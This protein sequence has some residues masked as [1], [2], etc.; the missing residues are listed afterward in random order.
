M[1]AAVAKHLTA[2]EQKKKLRQYWS[3]FEF[4]ITQIRFQ[5]CPPLFQYLIGTVL[6]HKA[7]SMYCHSNKQRKTDQQ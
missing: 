7:I 1:S 4:A 6:I 5:Q 2:V 3:I